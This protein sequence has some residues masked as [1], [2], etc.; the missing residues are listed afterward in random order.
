[1]ARPVS[2]LAR[3]LVRV[4]HHENV[5]ILRGPGGI[6]GVGWTA[7]QCELAEGRDDILVESL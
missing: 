4:N 7:A 6:H 2:G 1:M 3:Y 5:R